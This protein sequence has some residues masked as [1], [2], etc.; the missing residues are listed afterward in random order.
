MQVFSGSTDVTSQFNAFFSQDGVL[1][2]GNFQGDAETTAYTQALTYLRNQV[3]GSLPPA[4]R[5]AVTERFQSYIGL[6]QSDGCEARFESAPVLQGMYEELTQFIESDAFESVPQAMQQKLVGLQAE[7]FSRL[8]QRGTHR[9]IVPEE[10]G[11]S[12]GTSTE[13]A[14]FNPISESFTA[15]PLVIT[16]AATAG[17][18]I[19]FDQQCQVDLGDATAGGSL[20]IY[21]SEGAQPQPFS[22]TV[23]NMDFRY[24]IHQR[25]VIEEVEEEA[26]PPAESGGD[27]LDLDL[28]DP[29]G[30]L[31]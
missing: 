12:A 26:P 27:D 28:D 4:E 20:S 31:E 15:H 29:L 2:D 24:G 10:E 8:E 18:Q 16:N 21:G 22:G 7:A 5:Q 30:G 23:V 9:G 1:V 14:E 6:I 11:E 17:D 3:R 13:L 25:P 19:S